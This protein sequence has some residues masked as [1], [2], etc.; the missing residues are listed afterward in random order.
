M[1]TALLIALMAACGCDDEPDEGPS[2]V[3]IGVIYP[4][5]GS[6]AATGADLRRGV[7]LA[8]EIVNDDH[9][10]ALPLAAGEGLP[11][12]G[13]ARLRVVLADSAGRPDQGVERARALL[14]MGEVSA[15]L[16]AYQSSVTAEIS[17]V[18]EEAEIPL[19]VDPSAPSITRRGL[20]WTFRPSPDDTIFVG[21][22]FA[23]LDE[24]RA[25]RGVAPES[26]AIVYVDDLFGSSVAE[27]QAKA[28][29]EAGLPIV[30]EVAYPV[31]ASSFEP[32]A[33][34][35]AASGARLVLQ[36]S[37]EKDAI[38][39]VQAYEAIGHRPEAILAMDAGFISPAFIATLGDGANDVLSREV[40]AE[41]LGEA[42]PLVRQVSELFRA[43]YGESMTGNSAR[44][45]T[46]VLVLADAIDR[47]GTTD[48]EPIRRALVATELAPEQ[49]IMPWG[50]VRFDETG[51][52]ELARGIIVQIQDREYRTVW[53][54][55]LATSEV[56]WPMRSPPR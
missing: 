30:A 43:R 5:T 11:R 37:F 39:I 31:D 44:A 3:V 15:L 29:A 46:A 17:L 28:A 10:L 49:L 2:E 14:A 50:G 47:A 25:E 45:F 51:Q 22:Q 53:P 56:V 36:S 26:A 27:L 1:T 19:V 32:I 55:E 42:N 20:R 38:G 54:S 52:N 48:P 16:G 33:R 35:V 8:L 34:E 12:L 7:E 9:A 40:W 6:E 13:G 18:T 24:L 21:E 23:F 4:L 41:D